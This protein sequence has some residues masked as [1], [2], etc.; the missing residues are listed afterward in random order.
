[1]V[2]RCIDAE[3]SEISTEHLDGM[4]S[5][6]SSEYQSGQDT[7][8]MEKTCTHSTLRKSLKVSFRSGL[9]QGSV[10]SPGEEH[11]RCSSQ[12]H[13]SHAGSKLHREVDFETDETNLTVF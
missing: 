3:V 6:Y 13:A 8:L 4:H 11:Q 9:I 5:G 1:M 2:S 12:G 10:R 7:R